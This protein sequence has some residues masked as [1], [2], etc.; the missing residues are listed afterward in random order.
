LLGGSPRKLRDDAVADSVSKDGTLIAFG[1]NDG[2]FGDPEIWLMGPNRGNAR[3]LFDTD[4]NSAIRG[5][6][7]LGD[8]Q[9]T[10]VMTDKSGDTLVRRALNGGPATAIVTPDEMKAMIDP[11]L[12]PDGRLIYAKQDPADGACNYW[13]MGIRLTQVTLR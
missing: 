11:S 7:W 13:E 12:L 5:L 9:V 10:Y 4:E 2:K 3:K 1:S 8:E 6:N